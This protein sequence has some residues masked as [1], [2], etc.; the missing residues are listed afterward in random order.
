[1]TCLHR[2]SS[3]PELYDN[4]HIN[5]EVRIYHKDEL[6]TQLQDRLDSGE[7]EQ[8]KPFGPTMTVTL[9]Q[10]RFD[11]ETDEAVW[12]EDD[13]CSTPLAMERTEV[14]NDYLENI[15]IVE[16]DVDETAGWQ[17]IED[18]PELWEIHI[19]DT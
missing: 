18:L 8:M 6:V 1:M 16:E 9:R 2:Y 15:T 14:L 19:T 7:I 5:W 13:Y 10:A 3:Q 12:V 17:R 4:I 11:S